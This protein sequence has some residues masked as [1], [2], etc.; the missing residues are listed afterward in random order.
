MMTTIPGVGGGGGGG[1]ASAAR[2]AG[3]GQGG[4]PPARPL[5]LLVR[6]PPPMNASSSMVRQLGCIYSR[7]GFE[8]G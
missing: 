2:G 3:A 8:S 1:G 5:R 6:P 4:T 7:L